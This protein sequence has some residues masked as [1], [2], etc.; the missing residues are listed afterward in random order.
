MNANSW[1]SQVANSLRVNTA[2]AAPAPKAEH[3]MVAQLLQAAG[4]FEARHDQFAA[5][6]GETCRD[7]ALKLARFGDFASDKQK[8]FAE[9]LVAWSQ[10]R[11]TAEAPAAFTVPRL[12]AVMQRHAKFY[13]D[14]LKISRRNGDS[15]CWLN[16]NAT[17]VG[18]IEDG[19]VTLFSGRLRQFPTTEGRTVEDYVR[20]T[21]AEFEAHPLNAAMKYGKL[22][23]CCCS[24]GRDLT[25]PASIA[26]GIGPVCAGKFGG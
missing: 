1:Q 8:G 24:C 7:M 22:S 3:P 11:A 18:K 15:L 16:W 23:G 25:D 14:Q 5:G 10:P 21:L 19:V 20:A 17:C 4:R 26:A 9:K 12:F 13:A 6:K 2:P